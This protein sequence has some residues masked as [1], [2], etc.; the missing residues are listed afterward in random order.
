MKRI[1]QWLIKEGLF[2]PS[3]LKEAREIFKF[4]FK[5]IKQKK[6]RPIWMI[7]HLEKIS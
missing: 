5:P 2:N 1:R 4:P 7:K 3:S 6:Q